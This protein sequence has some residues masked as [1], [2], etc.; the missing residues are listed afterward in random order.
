MVETIRKTRDRTGVQVIARAAHILRTLE[1]ETSGLSLG[2]IAGRVG[3][4]RSTVQRIVGA[5]MEE[6]LVIQASDRGRV[7]LGPA[8]IRLGAA[9]SADII[10][11]VHPHLEALSIEVGETVDLS[12]LKRNAAVFVDQVAGSQRLAALSQVGTVFPLHSTA[13]GKALLSCMAEARRNELLAEPLSKDTIRTIT[14]TDKL[15]DEIQKIRH[16]GIAYDLEEHTAGICAIGTAFLDGFNR[17]HAI[18]I[19][20]PKTRYDEV[21]TA[22][23]EPLLVTRAKVIRQI[24]GSLPGEN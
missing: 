14:D 4:A 1:T 2:E 6:Q 10:S 12:V 5:L 15:A 16:T 17:P 7:K 8:L 20:V 23:K 18:S 13:N 19:P 22:L 3:L 11:L 21:A 9:A 24:G